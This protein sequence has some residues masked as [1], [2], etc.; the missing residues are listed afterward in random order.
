MYINWS[1]SYKCIVNDVHCTYELVW[2]ELYSTQYS[3]LSTTG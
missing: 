3:K 1:S 2:R